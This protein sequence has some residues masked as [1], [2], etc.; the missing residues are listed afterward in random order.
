MPKKLKPIY[1]DTK[2]LIGAGIGIG[3][4]S[5]IVSKAGAPAGVQSAFGIAAGFLPVVVTAVA[6]KHTLDIVDKGFNRRT[7]SSRRTRRL[8]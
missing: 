5:A 7:S 4:G 8:I 1:K 3:V 6:A 2:T